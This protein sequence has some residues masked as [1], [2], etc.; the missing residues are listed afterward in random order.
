MPPEE[1]R[2]PEVWDWLMEVGVATLVFLIGLAL[3]GYYILWW[4]DWYQTILERLYSFWEIIRPVIMVVSI[5][6]SIGLFGCI[7]VIFRRFVA[8]SPRLPLVISRAKGLAAPIAK[9]IPLEKEVGNEWQEVMKLFDSQ[10]S[11]DWSMAVLRADALLDDTLEYLKYEGKNL[12]ERLDRVDPTEVASLERVFSAHR[13]RNVI[14]HD[15]TVQYSKETILQG[16]RSY[17]QMLRELGVLKE[18][19]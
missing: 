13:L 17:E 9:A 11:S 10:N 18:E 16:L 6:V 8:L 19:Q 12:A 14:A 2:A 4:Y 15:P 7:I 1:R 5:L 3:L